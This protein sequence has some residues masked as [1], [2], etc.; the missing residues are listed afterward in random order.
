MSKHPDRTGES[1]NPHETCNDN[2]RRGFAPAGGCSVL[3]NI[4]KETP[5][6]TLIAIVNGVTSQNCNAINPIVVV[7]K[8]PPRIFFG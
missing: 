8:W 3:V 2:T 7:N 1:K 6:P 5:A 4:I